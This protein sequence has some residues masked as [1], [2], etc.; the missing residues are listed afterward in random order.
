MKSCRVFLGIVALSL[1]HG[2]G[3]SDWPLGPTQDA[4][5]AG[6]ALL[7][8]WPKEGP[9]VA[10]SAE[11]GEGYSSP[12]VA[13]NRLIVTHRL[14]DDLIV[15]CLEAMTGA[16]QWRFTH[17]MKFKDGAYM[18]NGPRPTPTIQ[19]GRVFVHNSDGYLVC[20]NLADGS[21]V[22]SRQA[23]SEFKSNATWHGA[24]ASPLARNVP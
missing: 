23:K 11:V 7:E 18:D 10:W 22:W 24:C 15:D 17:A 1:V 2:A 20:L 4:V 13:S 5:Y 14:N 12:V 9:R 21:K 8:T 16:K 6:P 3:A 19:G